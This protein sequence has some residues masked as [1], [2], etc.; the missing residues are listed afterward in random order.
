MV[1]HAIDV[2]FVTEVAGESGIEVKLK[3]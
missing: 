1:W 2:E 3:V